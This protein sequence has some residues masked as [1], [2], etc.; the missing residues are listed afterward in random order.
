MLKNL[1]QKWFGRRSKTTVTFALK[2]MKLDIGYS[3]NFGKVKEERVIQTQPFDKTILLAG[4]FAYEFDTHAERVPVSLLTEKNR[5][6]TLHVEQLIAFFDFLRKQC[7]D[8]VLYIQF[9][10]GED[11][12]RL[13]TTNGIPFVFEYCLKYFKGYTLLKQAGAGQWTPVKVLE[14]ITLEEIYRASRRTSSNDK[15]SV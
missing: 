2:L 13:V 11:C 9:E 7:S 12:R 6:S 15:K 5:I 4:N 8:R 10:L 14:N 1:L 3:Y